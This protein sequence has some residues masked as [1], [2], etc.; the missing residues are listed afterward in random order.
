PPPAKG[1]KEDGIAALE[2][3]LAEAQAG[4]DA[5]LD[6]GGG[7][8]PDR[9]TLVRERIAAEQARDALRREH[10]DAQTAVHV[11]RSE[12]AAETLRRQAL[13][14][15]TNELQNRLGEDL[16]T[17]PDDQRAERL[18]TLA[19][20]AAQAAA[21]FEAATERARR[22]RAAV[23]TA[24]QRAA[25]DARVKRLTQAIESRDKRLAE[26]EREIAGL[27]GRIATRGGEG[28]GE[29][30]AAAA[31]ELALAETDI[32]AIERRLAA[33]RLLR[34]TIADSRRAAHESYLKPVKTAMR[35]YLHALFPGADA[36]LDA[37][38]SVD[39]LTRAGADE[40]FVSLSDGTR[41]QVAIIVRLALGRLLAERGQ[42][43]PVV[44]DDSL[45]FS[46]DDRIERMFDVLTQAAEKQQVI[47]LTCRSRAFLSC[48]GRT[49]TIER[50]DG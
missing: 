32:A 39:G 13:T 7:P 50:E 25:L 23:P 47:V 12:D 21:A 37:G 29:R 17:C 40:P 41:E 45:V 15:E 36:A 38:F 16:A 9:D 44:L 48:G 33:L 26:V 11:A 35:P 42:A 30:E 34:D 46:D 4:L 5:G 43:V 6:A 14:L 18:V 1:G 3:A 2:Q 20:D 22:L 24:D 8:L 19:A 49:L 31:E 28:L 27:Q 10:A